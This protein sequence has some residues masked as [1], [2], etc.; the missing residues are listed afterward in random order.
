[1]K[2]LWVIT[3][4]LILSYLF[5]EL[6]ETPPNNLTFEQRCKDYII[7]EGINENTFNN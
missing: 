6:P 3:L 2:K 1:M 7:P 5:I 4:L